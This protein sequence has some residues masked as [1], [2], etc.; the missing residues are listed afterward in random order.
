MCLV[1]LQFALQKIKVIDLV[2]HFLGAVSCG[3]H[4]EARNDLTF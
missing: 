4:T 3:L 1:S 2:S